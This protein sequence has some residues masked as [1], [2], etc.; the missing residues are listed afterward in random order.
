MERV[1]GAL[2]KMQASARR[3]TL[4][5]SVA[6]PRTG[7]AKGPGKGKQGVLETASGRVQALQPLGKAKLPGDLLSPLSQHTPSRPPQP[8]RTTSVLGPC[9]I[10]AVCPRGGVV[11][12]VPIE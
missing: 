10:V 2:A 8:T 1:S 12:D 9:N 5:R 7:V 11:V 4:A 6:S 3:K